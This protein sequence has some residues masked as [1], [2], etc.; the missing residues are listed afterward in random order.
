MTTIYVKEQGAVIGRSGER[1][2]VRKDGGILDQFPLVNIEQVVLMGNV[3]LTTQA[4][5]TLLS[6]EVDV[7]FLSSYGK[8]R[9]R[10]VGSGSKN[11]QL[12]RR[13]L[14]L[15]GQAAFTLPLAKAIVDGKIHNQRVLLQRQLGR[16]APL[17]ELGSKPPVTPGVRAVVEKA[18]AGMEQMRQAALTTPNVDSVRGYEGKAAAYY[19]AAI[20]SLLDPDWRFQKRDYYP[21]PD[22]FNAL[23]SFAYSLLLKDVLA[24]VQLVGLDPYLGFFHEITYGRPSLALDLMEEWRPLLADALVLDLVNRGSLKP[25]DFT[26]TGQV[27]RPVELGEQGIQQV[28]EA[29]GRRLEREHYHP[30]AGGPGGQTPL[31]RI[32][33]L[34]V[35]RL[36]RVITG[37]DS[38]YEPVK[39]R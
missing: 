27:R 31:H 33:T 35:R 20:R 8:F 16:T 34:Q 11:A 2:V 32:I 4:T 13:Q 28:L 26:W 6:R 5:A 17:P 14:E 18:I 15:M 23:L 1:L 36:A 22:P 19:F 24:A 30:L 29:Y 25:A 39:A 37:K 3:Q 21:P 12:R 38:R 10:L 7:V 9:G